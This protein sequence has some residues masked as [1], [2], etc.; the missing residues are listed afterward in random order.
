MY[1]LPVSGLPLIEEDEATGEIATLFAEGKRALDASF[2][3]NMMKAVAI[4]I[5]ALTMCVDIFRTFYQ[6]LTLPQTLVA[7]ISYCI[8]MAKNCTYCAV[9]GELHCRSIGID[10]ETL[11]KL[12]RDVDSINPLRVR[13]II[14]FALKCAL[15]PQGLVADD[16]DQV[17]DQGVSDE[18]LVEI[19]VIVAVAN[20]ADTLADALKIEVDAPVLEAL[21]K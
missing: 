10:E 14:Q 3:P 12:A 11:E 17:R 4:S 7:M 16:Y 1:Q 20:L 6:N 18:E 21:G 5:P 8:P 2:V 19:I 9:N 13:A 15:D